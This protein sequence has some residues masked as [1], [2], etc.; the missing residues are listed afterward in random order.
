MKRYIFVFLIV[1]ANIAGCEGKETLPGTS[2]VA[3]ILPST[4]ADSFKPYTDH[5]SLNPE[6]MDLEER[7]TLSSLGKEVVALLDD[8]V[9]VFNNRIPQKDGDKF[10]AVDTAGSVRHTEGETLKLKATNQI[11]ADG[12]VVI[13]V[14]YA[15]LRHEARDPNPFW[16]GKQQFRFQIVDEKLKLGYWNESAP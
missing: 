4:D 1:L 16:S 7:K 2:P 9:H 13:I 8:Y 14:A 15:E 6:V 5:V 11:R 12:P 10:E 3:S